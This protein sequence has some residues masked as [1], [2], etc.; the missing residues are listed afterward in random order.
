VLA[1]PP[2]SPYRA[3]PGSEVEGKF[4]MNVNFRAK[5][6]CCLVTALAVWLIPV[7]AFADDGNL[8]QQLRMQQQENRFQLKLEQVREQARRR[9][10]AAQSV[11]AQ[12]PEAA[13]PMDM[14]EPDQSMRLATI[15]VSAP[16]SPSIDAQDAARIQ[17]Q[18]DHE[19]DQQRILD[20]RQQQR[21]LIAGDRLGAEDRYAAKRGELVRFKTQSRR[22]SLQRK[23]RY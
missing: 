18:Q 10:A 13:S 6:S 16:A 12:R 3:G 21:A 23:L 22:Q 17:T 1:A 5:H 15:T 9:A 8:D 20:Q 4:S 7:G 2:A 11:R 19:R 14:G